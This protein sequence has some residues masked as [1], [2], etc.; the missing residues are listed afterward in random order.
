MKKIN[1]EKN[2]LIL[3]GLFLCSLSV[4][5]PVDVRKTRITAGDTIEL[6][7]LQINPEQFPRVDVIFRA[8][9]QKKEPIW[10]LTSDDMTVIEEVDTCQ[11]I[12]FELLSK[13]M[14]VNI[15]LVTDHS[16]SMEVANAFYNAQSG[17]AK[18]L[19]NLNTDKDS[20]LIVGFSNG[21]DVVTPLTNDIELLNRELQSMRVF[22]A[23][24]FYDALSTAID[25][26]QQ[27]SGIRAIIALTDGE[28]NS[29][30]YSRRQIIQKGKDSGVP[31]YIIGL[32]LSEQNQ[33]QALTILG[34]L[35]GFITSDYLSEFA[36][37]LGGEAYFTT[38]SEK[39]TDIYHEIALKVYS[40]YLLTYTSENMSPADTTRI[41]DFQVGTATTEYDK[42]KAK[43]T[44]SDEILE[45]MGKLP[46]LYIAIPLGIITGIILLF[47]LA[48]KDDVED[49]INLETNPSVTDADSEIG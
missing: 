34:L 10:G 9:N 13:E 16:G 23:T 22:G 38:S 4:A 15:A 14:P 42:D 35:T 32:G 5:Q 44:L 27:H 3:L 8:E 46:L 6:K 24:A 41:V 48:K 1:I 29:S 31:T 49:D 45:R 40:I 17:I 37:E 12:R 20:V 47:G 11:I 39:L 33:P 36:D 7:T 43:Y 25:S 19:E 2:L 30:R 18:L 21:V 26:I 28:D